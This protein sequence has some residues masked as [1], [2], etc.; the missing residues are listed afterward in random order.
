MLLRT[1]TVSG[2][3]E[4]GAAC[5][6]PFWLE[7]QWQSEAPRITPDRMGILLRQL[8]AP[9]VRVMLIRTLLSAARF[10]SRRLYRLSL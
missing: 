7:D 5:A 2:N 6:F 4:P 10:S 3:Y 9:E 1:L 8:G